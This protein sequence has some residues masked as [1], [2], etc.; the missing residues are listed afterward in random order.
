MWTAD[1]TWVKFEKFLKLAFSFP[2]F[3]CGA[4]TFSILAG[5]KHNSRL[6]YQTDRNEFT[7]QSRL[8]R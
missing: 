8:F 4:K 7:L 1:E 5:G 6:F 3:R 2:R